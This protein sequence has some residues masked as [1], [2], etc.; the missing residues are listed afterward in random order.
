MMMSVIRIATSLNPLELL[1]RTFEASKLNER[2]QK[3]RIT[4]EAILGDLLCH[5]VKLYL[6]FC[7]FAIATP[8]R[9]LKL[10]KP[11]FWKSMVT[12]IFL[13]ESWPSLNSFICNIGKERG[14]GVTKKLSLRICL[15]VCFAFAYLPLCICLCVFVRRMSMGATEGDPDVRLARWKHPIGVV[16]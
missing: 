6:Y 10:G 12:K 9:K 1:Q 2:N 7:L 11:N 13:A 5:P 16:G 4:M 8:P 3:N 14:G 15:C